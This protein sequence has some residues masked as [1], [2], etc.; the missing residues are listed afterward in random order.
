MSHDSGIRIFPEIQQRL[1]NWLLIVVKY[2]VFLNDIVVFKKLT[3]L[4]WTI[5]RQH[6]PD[7]YPS[8]SE[9]FPLCC[10]REAHTPNHFI[11]CSPI[12]TMID[13]IIATFFHK[14]AR[15]T[16]KSK[17]LTKQGFFVLFELWPHKSFSLNTIWPLSLIHDTDK[18]LP[19]ILCV[20]ATILLRNINLFTVPLT[21]RR[22]K[23]YCWWWNQKW[24]EMSTSLS[25]LEFLYWNSMH[26]LHNLC[27]QS[28]TPRRSFKFRRW[29]YWPHHDFFWNMC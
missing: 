11:S 28:I 26:P 14:K 6:L 7:W 10:R 24:S 1:G 20:Y 12:V 9:K 2:K 15:F 27:N 13:Y 25:T 19:A 21:S 3:A 18:W 16:L 8:F 23:P 22:N 5:L 4:F 29:Q 17:L